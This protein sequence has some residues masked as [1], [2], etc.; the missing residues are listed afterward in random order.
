MIN[1]YHV[2]FTLKHDGQQ[3]DNFMHIGARNLEDAYYIA[4][5]W[6]NQLRYSAVYKELE[7]RDI[8]LVV[9]RV[10]TTAYQEEA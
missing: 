4:Q 8:T 6:R 3:T 7:V 10:Q 2:S 9:E 5:S 1:I